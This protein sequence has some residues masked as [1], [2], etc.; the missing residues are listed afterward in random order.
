MDIH[1]CGGFL[2]IMT[3]KSGVLYVGSTVDLEGRVA[4]H[5]EGSYPGS[6]TAKYR[7]VR[8]LYFEEH[9]TI[10]DARL[11]EIQIKKWKRSKKIFL[12][13]SINPAW[14]DLSIDLFRSE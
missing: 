9:E 7:C 12:I 4:M 1:E 8:L 2:Y 14:A 6:F 10:D 11:R 3:S 13:N 5:K